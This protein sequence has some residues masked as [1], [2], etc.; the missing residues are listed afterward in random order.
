M[1]GM[2]GASPIKPYVL[3]G[4]VVATV[5]GRRS[6]RTRVPCRTMPDRQSHRTRASIEHY[7][8]SA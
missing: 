1:T 6:H 5:P 8:L 7:I 3:P 4:P 2:T